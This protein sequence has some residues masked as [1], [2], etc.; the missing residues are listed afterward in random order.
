MRAVDFANALHAKF[1]ASRRNGHKTKTAGDWTRHVF[2]LLKDIAEESDLWWAGRGQG[3]ASQRYGEA[4]EYVWDFTM[5]DRIVGKQ[6][7]EAWN[8]PCVV[9][10]HENAHSLLAFRFDHWKTLFSHAPLRIAIGYVGKHMAKRRGEWVQAINDASD[11]N[12]WHFPP[13]TEDLIALGYY[14]MTKADNNFE[15]W[16][17]RND[18]REWTPLTIPATAA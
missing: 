8:L 17:R 12:A 3:K 11:A 9:I 10:E 16:R 18:E 4:R 2:P 15:F 14:G 7:A 6:P 5:Y 1:N 13:N